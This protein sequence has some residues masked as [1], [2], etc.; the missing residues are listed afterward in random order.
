MLRNALQVVA[1][2]V[3]QPVSAPDPATLIESIIGSPGGRMTR[4]MRLF[5]LVASGR[6]RPLAWLWRSAAC[7]MVPRRDAAEPA[8]AVACAACAERGWPVVVRESGG[9]AFPVGAGSVQ[10]STFGLLGAGESEPTERSYRRLCDPIIAALK[11]LGISAAMRRVSGALCEGAYD[12]C[13]AERKIA[14]TAQRQRRSTDGRSA[15]LAHATINIAGYERQALAAVKVYHRIL[16][17]DVPFTEARHVSLK[18]C[19]DGAA[20][21]TDEDWSRWAMERIAAAYDRAALMSN[22]PWNL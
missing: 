7:I 9:T 8:F 1:D 15:V 12:I 13:I 20:H 14:G 21:G 17:R 22:A 19:L 10:I 11:E 2:D 5:G 18:E 3:A 4:E 16:G 6:L